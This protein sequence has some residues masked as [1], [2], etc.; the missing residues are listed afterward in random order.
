VPYHGDARG[1]VTRSE[2]F[3]GPAEPLEA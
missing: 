2:R 1:E 3:G